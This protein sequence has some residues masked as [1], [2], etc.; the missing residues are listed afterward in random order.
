MLTDETLVAFVTTSRPKEARAF[1][2]GVLG[3]ALVS[4]GDHL[5]VFE[6]G[7]AR[8]SLVKGVTANVQPGTAVGWSV[9]DLRMSIREL[10]ARGVTTFDDSGPDKDELGIWSP[11]PGHGV[12]WFK[13][14]DGHTLSVAG[15]I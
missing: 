10:M 15:P 8:I 5:M 2:E 4:D 3:L 13:D 6:S 12:A 7:P 1:Y 11:V 9:K 14:P